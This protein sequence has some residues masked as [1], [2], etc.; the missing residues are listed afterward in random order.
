MVYCF[1]VAFSVRVLVAELKHWVV[2]AWLLV[3]R[4]GFQGVI[5]GKPGRLPVVREDRRPLDKA[6]FL[7]IA[8]V[9]SG[10][11]YLFILEIGREL[12][13]YRELYRMAEDPDLPFGLS[14]ALRVMNVIQQRMA[15]V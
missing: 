7:V 2:S 6:E 1:G 11:K 9:R 5:M 10:H 8:Y 13:L 3:G 14:D 4:A 15:C 12:D